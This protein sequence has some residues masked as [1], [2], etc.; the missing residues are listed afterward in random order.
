MNMSFR[1]DCLC[2]LRTYINT[3]SFNLASL[4]Q[5]TFLAMERKIDLKI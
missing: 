3:N 4:S 1:G 5:A 2:I